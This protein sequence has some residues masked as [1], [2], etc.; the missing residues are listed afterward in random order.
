M[1]LAD[2]RLKELGG[3]PATVGEFARQRCRAASDLIHAGQY[4]AARETLGELW[5]G[6]GRRPEVEGLDVATA[7]ELLLQAGV[8]SGWLGT[9]R[10]VEGS[11]EAA[12]D[13]IS[14]SASLFERSGETDR[15]AA[16]RSEL[17]L[18]YWREGAY[19]EA[20]VTLEAAAAL[21][22]DD[23]QLKAKTVLRLAI[24]DMSAGLYGEALR[25]LTDSAQLFEGVSHTLRSSF[26]NELANALQIVGEAERR[27]DYM[28]R[29]IIEYTAAVFHAELAGHEQYG[30]G[31]ENNLAFLLYKLGRYADAHEHLDRAQSVITR[32]KDAGRQAQ[33]DETRARVLLAEKRY[34]EAERVIA[35]VCETLEQGDEAALLADALTVR[36]VVSARLGNFQSSAEALQRAASVAEA[37]GALSKAGLALLSLVEEHGATRRLTDAEVYETYLRADGLLRDAQDAETLGR[38]RACARVVMHRMAGPQLGD[39][40]FTMYGAVHD[41]EARLIERALDEACG[42]VTKAARLLG[43]THQTLGTILNTRHRLLADKRT[44]VKK[45][46]RSIIKKPRAGRQ[47]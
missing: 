39:D 9:G 3:F 28:D 30:A 18:C 20:R 47:Q 21:I 40:N 34:R 1:T 33:F 43:L 37:A 29:A 24:V 8:L 35:R 15:V 13:L 6:V 2:E 42:S 25:L 5:R 46:L 10:Q 31:V 16:A 36:G 11:Q 19:A 38:L 7:A 4:E 44:P 32:I 17:A 45:R 26:H 23:A 22:R 41:F 12:K 27:A 14:E